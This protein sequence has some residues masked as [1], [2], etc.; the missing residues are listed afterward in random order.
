VIEFLC[1]NGHRIHCPAEQAGRAAKCPR[2]GVKFVVPDLSQA[3]A[4][5]S[6]DSGSG[7]S[8]PELS[9]SGVAKLLP[10]GPH[11][12]P[13]REPQIE[14]LCPN[15]HRL[16]G[17]ASLQGRPG[18]C[19]ECGSRFRIPTYEGVLEDEET[20]SGI[21]V[22]RIDGSGGSS[23]VSARQGGQSGGRERTNSEP[24]GRGHP[25]A[26]LF[27]KLWAERPPGSAIQ[28]HLQGGETLLPEQFAPELSQDSHGVFALREPGGTHTLTVVAWDSVVRVQIRGV[29]E[30]PEEMRD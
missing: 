1:P 24:A 29:A 8:R 12:G 22:G 18:K 17:A 28:L 10:E 11:E 16:H 7:P 9:D 14:F 25:L 5:D 21:G 27:C 15:G 6:S 4:S 2:C 30:L 26:G 13:G 23:A 3:Q 19:P 20:E